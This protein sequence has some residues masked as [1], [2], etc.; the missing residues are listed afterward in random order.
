[1][2]FEKRDMGQ[3]DTGPYI[4]LACLKKSLNLLFLQILLRP[5]DKCFGLSWK[6][7]K[8]ILILKVDFTS[9]N[10]DWGTDIV[11][12]TQDFCE[13]YKQNPNYF[14]LEGS[15]KPTQTKSSSQKFLRFLCEFN[16]HFLMTYFVWNTIEG[17]KLFKTRK[18]QIYWSENYK[19]V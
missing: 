7:L 11:V 3:I 1:M 10:S 17:K 15:Q 18:V 19:K 13:N 6:K 8:V 5:F 9:T 12:K 16:L 2:W 4:Y 14:I